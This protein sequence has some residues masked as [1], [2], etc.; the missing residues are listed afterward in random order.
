MRCT[1]DTDRP[2]ACAMPRELQ[3]V[4]IGRQALQRAHDHRFDAGILDRARRAGARL[5]AQPVH[6]MLDKAPT[7]L[8]DVVCR[9][10][11]S[12]AATSLFSTPSAQA[13]TI[14]A[15][16]A[17]ACAVF[18]RT[19][20]EVSSARS[21]SL[22]IRG[23]SCWAAI[24]TPSLF[25]SIPGTATRIYCESTIAKLKLGTLGDARNIASGHAS[26]PAVARAR[27]RLGTHPNTGGVVALRII[28]KNQPNPCVWRT[29]QVFEVCLPT[30]GN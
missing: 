22:K 17:S 4:R 20:S 29:P 23:A 27:P 5:V 21:S 8:A 6:A 2:L 30:R 11:P 14:R 24:R 13:S 28:G 15:R 25:A 9:S 10:T 7:P 26:I 18:R 12:S 1:V 19:P 16:S 3:C